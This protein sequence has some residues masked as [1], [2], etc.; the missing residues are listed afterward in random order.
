MCPKGTLIALGALLLA[1]IRDIRS[2]IEPRSGKP[3]RKVSRKLTRKR[4]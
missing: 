3:E 1:I 4:H 2:W